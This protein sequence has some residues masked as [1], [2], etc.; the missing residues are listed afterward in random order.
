MTFDIFDLHLEVTYHLDIRKTERL[1]LDLMN[2]LDILVMYFHPRTRNMTEHEWLTSERWETLWDYIAPKLTPET[3]ELII[4]AFQ[5][6]AFH[7][8]WYER[9]PDIIRDIVGNPFRPMAFHHVGKGEYLIKHPEDG[10]LVLSTLPD[11][12]FPKFANHE[13]VFGDID[14]VA[15]PAVIRVKGTPVTV[16]DPAWLTWNNRTI[17]L[18]I[19][20]MM[21]EDCA[22]CDFPRAWYGDCDC[23]EGRIPRAEPRWEIMP[24]IADALEE[25][26][27]RDQ[28]ILEHLRDGERCVAC[29]GHGKIWGEPR[30]GVFEAAPV[31]KCSPCKGTGRI[32]RRHYIGCHIIELLKGTSP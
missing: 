6:V 19:D 26:G 29:G 21:N 14:R 2:H 4:K 22:K 5:S 17:P 1:G 15:S 12:N 31:S 8:D 30:T 27:C 28:Y 9:R 16:L 24:V 3:H 13:P 18:M 20:A 10:R 23:D 32:K 11:P 25:A 7:A